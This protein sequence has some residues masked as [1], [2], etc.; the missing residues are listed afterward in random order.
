MAIRPHGLWHCVMEQFADSRREIT[1]QSKRLWHA[2]LSWDRLPE[3]LRI[4][5]DARTVGIESGEQRIATGTT[6]RKR[7]VGSVEQDASFCQSVDVWRP[8][9]WIAVTA[10]EV[11]E[12]IR[13]DEQ[14]IRARLLFRCHDRPVLNDTTKRETNNKQLASFHCHGRRLPIGMQTVT[15]Q[16]D[17]D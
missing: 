4:S 7:A 14:N 1:A 11:V 6:Q 5:Q 8:G 2:E 3:D 15:V 10:K 9:S 17:A 16:C 12:I 13:D